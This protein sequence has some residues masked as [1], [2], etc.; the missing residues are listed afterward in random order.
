[1]VL[2]Q[3]NV[4]V[5]LFLSGPGPHVPVPANEKIP[6]DFVRSAD[7]GVVADS[8]LT[9]EFFE[10]CPDLSG[11]TGP[12]AV[13]FICNTADW[14]WTPP[15]LGF[16]GA[17]P[18]LA[19]ACVSFCDGTKCDTMVF[20]ISVF[21]NFLGAVTDTALTVYG[22]PVSIPVLDNDWIT[23]NDIESI[24]LVDHP[25]KGEAELIFDGTIAYTPDSGFCKG[26]DRFSYG[27][28]NQTGC[29]TTE[30][31]VMLKD[32]TG[33]C[34]GVWPGDVR[35]DGL[36]NVIDFWAVGL[37]F[38]HQNTGPVRP[39]ATA[40]WT[41][42]PSPD[43]ATNI[44]FIE[45]INRKHVDCN[46]DGAINKLDYEVIDQNWGKFHDQL[47]VEKIPAEASEFALGIKPLGLEKEVSAFEVSWQNNPDS[48]NGFA[49]KIKLPDT[50]STGPQWVFEPLGIEMDTAL[51][52]PGFVLQKY[53]P[54]GNYVYI[55]VSSPL[56]PV[57]AG[58]KIGIIRTPAGKAPEIT[59][60]ILL[61]KDF[62][63]YLIAGGKEEQ[64]PEAEEISEKPK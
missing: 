58:E 5:L 40:E 62:R 55:A 21:D 1:M 43:W 18:G 35:P 23:L 25:L 32:E 63:V 48:L 24:Y 6:W 12:V 10:Y 31:V 47:I 56:K 64:P 28:C 44:T 46:G 60:G 51:T 27:I 16:V 45:A 50:V 14:E 49:F 19:E 39:D 59:D 30:V 29:D 15:C 11:M 8:I 20:S 34:D 61:G 37:G 3:I 7:P 22:E 53:V 42:Q 54:E 17:G 13:N 52:K 38:Y 4:C 41:A 36:V 9:G 2:L 33:I 26:Q 57:R